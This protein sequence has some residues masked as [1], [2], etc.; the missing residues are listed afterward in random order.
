M[1]FFTL[2]KLHI[3]TNENKNRAKTMVNLYTTSNN[4]NRQEPG[5]NFVAGVVKKG[6]GY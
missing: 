6:R 2:N 5:I 1:L 4:K 3:Y